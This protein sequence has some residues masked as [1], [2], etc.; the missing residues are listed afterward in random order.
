M[1]IADAG[2]KPPPCMATLLYCERG[3]CGPAGA[4][5][6][7]CSSAFFSESRM[8]PEVGGVT[9]VTAGRL[10][11]RGRLADDR[12]RL[13]VV[14]RV[15]GQEQ[16]GDEEAD[17]Q[18]R[19]GARQQIGGAT[20]RHEAG[21]AAH[22]KAAAFGFL[23]QHRAD[24]H[25]DD[26]EVDDDDDSLHRYLPSQG[27]RAGSGCTMVLAGF[28][29]VARC[30]TIGRGIATPDTTSRLPRDSLPQSQGN[31]PLSGWRRRPERR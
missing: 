15:P 2:R 29:E 12:G 8:P 28:P 23:Q 4:G 11:L 18:D 27:R 17:R 6:P 24:H 14:A 10:R 26:H 16:A 30:Y 5:W 3:A 21:A 1:G 25:G 7:C 20:A 13:A 9:G 31:R 22:A 19:R